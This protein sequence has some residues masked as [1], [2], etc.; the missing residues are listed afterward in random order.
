MS[1]YVQ[2]VPLEVSAP[3]ITQM[4]PASVGGCM[5]ARRVV[6]FKKKDCMVLSV[7]LCWNILKEA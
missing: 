4:L 5:Y 3:F 6:I 2:Y 7:M 1:Y